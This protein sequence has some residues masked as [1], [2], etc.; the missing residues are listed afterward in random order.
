M[1]MCHFRV[2]N[3]PIC[4]EQNFLVQTIIITF[5]YLLALFIVQNLKKFFQ[6]IQSYEDVQFLGPKWPISPNE[7][8][9]RKPVNEPCFF[10]SCLSTC[11]KSK[12]DINLLVKYWWLKNTKISLVERHFW[13]QLENQIFPIHAVFTECYWTT[14]T[15]LYTNCRQNW[16]SYFLKKSKNHVFGLFLTIFGHFYLIFSP[17]KPGSITHNYTRGPNIMLK[18]WKN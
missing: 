11:Q 10:Y 16:W 13:L 3:T 7:N 18:F 12:S 5:I 14:R 15:S 2:Q 9:F 6:R 4:P 8:F 17:K 1:R